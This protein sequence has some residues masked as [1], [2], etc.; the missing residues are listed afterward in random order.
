MEALLGGDRRYPWFASSRKSDMGIVGPSRPR[1]NNS[2]G[3]GRDTSQARATYRRK[4][5]RGSPGDSGKQA[6]LSPSASAFDVAAWLDE[7]KAQGRAYLDSLK[8]AAPPPAAV[9]ESHRGRSPGGGVPG[10][11]NLEQW[12]HTDNAQPAPTPTF[13]EDGVRFDQAPPWKV[14]RY[15]FADGSAET[16]CLRM[17]T[18]ECQWRSRDPFAEWKPPERT[19]EEIEAR[20]GDS[21]RRSM[22]RARRTLRWNV[23]QLQLDR[24]LTLTTRA[25]IEQR[26][27][28]LEVFARFVRAVRLQ[29]KGEFPYQAVLELQ[30]RGAYHAHL[31]IKGWRDVR[32][33][34][35]LWRKAL[36]SD[37]PG[38]DSPGN[39]QISFKGAL[40]RKK[41]IA[42][43]VKY[44][45]KDIGSPGEPLDNRK[46]LFGTKGAP[47]RRA[48]W[49]FRAERFATVQEVAAHVGLQPG[50]NEW[51]AP[52]GHLLWWESDG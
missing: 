28:F 7:L 42:Y 34:R 37:A 45:G 44:I 21:A 51:I 43:L 15:T 20:K 19:Q 29:W 50:S 1:F 17:S 14:T 12:T 27:K 47:P 16:T 39:V 24:M 4:A 31:A 52:G 33:L 3:L 30:A 2:G 32:L 5:P 10:V 36:G 9:P 48:V 26:D 40:P 38:A 13:V 25:P 18:R 41:L 46:R 49:I 6:P 35:S 23:K 8:L 22:E 11:S